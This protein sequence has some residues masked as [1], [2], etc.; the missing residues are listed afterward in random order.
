LDRRQS[1][2]GVIRVDEYHLYGY[3]I[4]AR[5]AINFHAVPGDAGPLSASDWARV[6]GV[7]YAPHVA[8]RYGT[9]GSIWPA[10]RRRMPG[11]PK[12]ALSKNQKNSEK[13]R[14]FH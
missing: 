12:D 5:E 14:V 8:C 7:L 9:A 6:D 1:A 13:T 11:A 3:T 10:S 2:I 4:A